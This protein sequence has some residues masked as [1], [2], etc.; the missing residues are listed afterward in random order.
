VIRRRIAVVAPTASVL[1]AA[2]G[3]ASETPAASPPTTVATSSTIASEQVD[4]P[5][6]A[7]PVTFTTQDLTL[8]DTT[9]PTPESDNGP[10]LASRAIGLR[11]TLPDTSGPAPLVVFS[12]GMAGHPDAFEELFAVWAEAGCAQFLGCRRYPKCRSTRS[13]A[14]G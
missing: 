13:L 9:R 10:Q 11:L 8:V 12:H 2:C 6:G 1:V 5:R 3:G 7:R 14:K 4:D